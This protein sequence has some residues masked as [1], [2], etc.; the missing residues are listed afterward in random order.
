M[1]HAFCHEF[2]VTRCHV[3]HI[4]LAWP[5]FGMASAGLVIQSVLE[6]LPKWRMVCSIVQELQSDGRFHEHENGKLGPKSG[7]QSAPWNQ[8]SRSAC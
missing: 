4:T 8:N 6:E 7:H 1:F 3:Y 2:N 5:E